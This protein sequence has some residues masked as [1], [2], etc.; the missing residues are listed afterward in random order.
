MLFK[1]DIVEPFGDDEMNE[2]LTEC[3]EDTLRFCESSELKRET[4]NAKNSSEVYPEGFVAKTARKEIKADITVE[5][6]TTLAAA[7][8]YKSYGR[9]AVLNFAN[10][11]VPGGGVKKGAVAQEECLCRC[12]NLY[13]CIASPAVYDDFYGYHYKHGRFFY[14]DR[15]IYTKDVTVFKD[16]NLNLLD[17][18]QWF[19]VDVLTCSAPFI[20][21]RKYTNKA[22][23]YELF[24]SR[25]KNIINIAIDNNVDVL[26]LGAFGCGAFKNP[27][28]LVAKAFKTVISDNHYD[29]YFR[30]IVFA[31]K[32]SN[33]DDPFEPCP[34][35][36]AFEYEFDGISAEANKLRFFAPCASEQ[37]GGTIA[38]PSG[39]VLSDGKEVYLYSEWKRTNKFN[40]KQFS[41]LGDSISTL[42]GYNP[43]GYNV[44]FTGEN[45]QKS[46]VS[47]VD[48][49]WW[50]HVISFCGGELLVNNSLSGSRVTKLPGRD[51]LFPSGCSDERTNRLHIGNSVI[52]AEGQYLS[53]KG[54]EVSY[55]C[56]SC[57][58][59]VLV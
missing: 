53:R 8:R 18:K 26:I 38:L 35:L 9:V 11:E 34:N 29:E 33:D 15:V 10:P 49:T 28:E 1:C 47:D 46:D 21:K 6:M 17:R 30:K 48:D 12:S 44:F 3:F 59:F 43:H 37:T 45:C 50:G 19:N 22:A 52:D 51:S 23:L 55:K 20:A 54:K 25:V 40:G 7:E 56:V 32:S 24:K 2:R 14:S 4:E 58:A 5:N 13:P 31:I 39:R 57:G 41:V 42:E 36:M 27:P 16:D